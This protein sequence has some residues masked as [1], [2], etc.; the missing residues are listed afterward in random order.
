VIGIALF[1]ND[2]TGFQTGDYPRLF[3]N[4]LRFACVIPEPGLAPVLGLMLGLAA[5]VLRRR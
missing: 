1:P 4:A 5:A 3:G 2:V